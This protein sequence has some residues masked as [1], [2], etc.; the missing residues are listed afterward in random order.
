MRTPFILVTAA[1]LAAPILVGPAPGATAA[2]TDLHG[3]LQTVA[4]GGRPGGWNGW[5]VAASVT[6]HGAPIATVTADAAGAFDLD[7]DV[8]VPAD[9]ILWLIARAPADAARPD[10]PTAVLASALTGVPAQ[11]VVVNERTTIATAWA[12]AQ[13]VDDD[14]IDGTAPGLRNAAGMAANLADP[15]TGRA[16]A[17][18]A[19]SPNGDETSTLA[20]FGS[21]TAALASCVVDPFG[22][23]A[24]HP[25]GTCATII[26]IAGEA[27]DPAV[28]SDVFRAF[29]EIARN[30]AVAAPA[31]LFELSTLVPLSGTTP[32]LTVP[33]A[34]WTLAIR[35][36]GDG[37]SLDGPGN[38]AIDHE[39][40]L[41]VNNNYQYRPQPKAPACG[42]DALFKFSPTGGFEKFT[43][44]GLSGAGYGIELDERTG[45]VWV[46]N[47]GFSAPEPFCK[48]KRQPPHDTASLFSPD[49]V[50][51]SGAGGFTEGGLDWP[52]GIE[53]DSQRSVWFANCHAD[54]LTLYPGGD[55]S[56]ARAVPASELQLV[57]PFDVVDNG[58]RIFASGMVNS[59]VQMLDYDGNVL[60][61][62]PG[63]NAA[64]ANPMGLAADGAGN[65]WAANSFLV[66]LPCP[67]VPGS[68]STE[69]D[70]SGVLG[71]EFDA[72]GAY[73]GVGPNPYLGSV[74][75]IAPDG[76]SVTK[77]D[78]GGTTLPWGITTDGDGNV[79]VANFAGKRLSAFCGADASTC[80]PGVA[81]GDPISPDLT[82]FFFDG[83][84]RNTGV[85]VDQSGHVWVANNWIEIPIQTNPG[86]HEIV[87]F[88]G[89]AEPVE[90]P[91]PDLAG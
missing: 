86:G 75:M 21:L 68:D 50:A 78:G 10:A 40:N 61:G 30:P 19:G 87:A 26:D 47:F 69:L 81:T 2:G 59:A 85:A 45:E 54:T 55:R 20:A 91:A 17:M 8:P 80:P 44:G 11:S 13:F 7:I 89:L 90:V 70:L 56:A 38:F 41:W 34:A 83:L 24:A 32:V 4:A 23:P 18:L 15:A 36:D 31:R 42:S 62:S 76:S 65:V 74:A 51:L 3:S 72:V 16:A 53:V 29:A 52:Q 28:P 37:R 84:V 1:I 49:G 25:G 35:F 58:D 48:K 60:P 33:P 43:G 14:G 66:E 46:S 39:G 57:E 5:E 77:Y 63:A 6:G 82:G 9:G 88:L 73:T 71:A 27:D 79:W 64:F 67:T 12:M 22:H